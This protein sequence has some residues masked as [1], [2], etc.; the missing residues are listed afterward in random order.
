MGRASHARPAIFLAVRLFHITS[1]EEWRAAQVSGE[2]QPRAY[3]REGFIHCSYAGQVLYTANRIFKGVND[4]VLLEIE[5]AHL[6]C[7]VVDENL[8]GGTELFPHVYGPLP[9]SAVRTVH[10]LP[11]DADGTFG[12]E[13]LLSVDVEA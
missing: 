7:A 6:T 8:E 3:S 9:V 12:R 2:Y 5:T 13:L 11:C 1:K 10:P 4:L